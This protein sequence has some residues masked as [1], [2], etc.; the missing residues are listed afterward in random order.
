MPTNTKANPAVISNK[1]RQAKALEL[2]K[3]G[4]TY[5][6]IAKQL[7]YANAGSAYRSVQTALKRLVNEPAEEL[8]SIEL[9]RLNTILLT[10]WPRVQ[11]GDYPAIDRAI[12]V[13]ER[14]AALTGYDRVMPQSVTQNNVIVIEGNERDY[15]AGLKAMK[16]QAESL[17]SSARGDQVVI[18]VEPID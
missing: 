6:A 2:R 17:M 1:Q 5:E 12:R 8:R 11:A 4:A 18:D 14:I 7:G 10:L 3:A 16:A 15:I 9:E 13:G